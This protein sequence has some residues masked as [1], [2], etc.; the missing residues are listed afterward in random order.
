MRLCFLH[1]RIVAIGVS[2]LAGGCSDS[3]VLAPQAAVRPAAAKKLIAKLVFKVPHKHAAARGARYVSPATQS[4]TVDIESA[5][6]ST[7]ATTGYPV[8]VSLTP[9]SSGCTSTLASTVCTLS[10]SLAPGS[11]TASVTAYDG[12]DG[13][14]NGSNALSAA[15]AVPFTISAGGANSIAL[16]LG[17][18]PASLV[19]A[20]FAPG[21]LRGGTGGLTLYGAATQKLVLQALDADGDVI[22]G[23]G[24]PTLSVTPT[25]SGALTVTG[26]TTAAANVVTLQASTSGTPAVV[27]PQALEL[28]VT[29]TPTSASGAAPLTANIPLRIAHSAVYVSSDAGPSGEVDV[30]YDGNVSGSSP[31]LQITNNIDYPGA[32][33]VDAAGTLYVPNFGNG[34][35]TEYPAGSTSPTV[36]ISNGISYPQGAAVDAAG[37]LYVVSDGSSVAEY[38]AGSTASSSPSVTLTNGIDFPNGVAVDAAGTLYVANYANQSY[39]TEYP[40]GSTS[41]SL[42][43]T[44]GIGGAYGVAVDAA[45]TL[46][47]LNIHSGTVTEYPAGSTASS[48]PT[49]TI[50]NGISQPEGVA[51]DAAGTLY[52][53]N[54]GIGKITEYPAGSTALSSPSVTLSNGISDPHGLAVDAAGTLYVVTNPSGNAVAEYPAGSTSSSS[55][56]ATI[57]NVV[58]ARFVFA[59]PGPLTP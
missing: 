59:V 56:T 17:G 11:Y 55:P 19:V 4:V 6:P 41:P 33:A 1:F 31:N 54:Y 20:P 14:G 30:F 52:V 24:A 23:A 3:S 45:G 35:V 5:S 53:A 38:P 27:T 28:A 2:L 37:T 47:V 36:T 34:T 39:V 7:P 49:V 26:P 10:V 21:Y 44:N 40:A 18:I 58:D 9:T 48:S 29:A 8:T 13:A 25:V 22:A 12:V 32:V 15:V 50:S 46:Y 57:S 51:V 42:K 16:T 43:I